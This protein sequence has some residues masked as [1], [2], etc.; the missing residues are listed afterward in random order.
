M[1]ITY[2]PGLEPESL[3]TVYRTCPFTSSDLP[4]VS[5]PS[6]A[7]LS[8]RCAC[9]PPGTPWKQRVF[10]LYPS[11]PSVGSQ[12]G[13]HPASFSPWAWPWLSPSPVTFQ[14]LPYLL[15]NLPHFQLFI[16]SLPHSLWVISMICFLTLYFPFQNTTYFCPTLKFPTCHFLSFPSI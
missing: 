2:L 14:S 9:L 7:K 8:S 5:S 12:L 1:Y 10:S 13:P 16:C 4:S 11:V 6:P 3:V 15:V